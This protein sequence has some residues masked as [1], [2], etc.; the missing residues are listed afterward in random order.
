MRLKNSDAFQLVCSCYA[1]VD[2]QISK[3]GS[4]KHLSE[5]AR[6]KAGGREASRHLRKACLREETYDI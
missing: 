2:V 6:Q 1:T 5:I 3:A 4:E